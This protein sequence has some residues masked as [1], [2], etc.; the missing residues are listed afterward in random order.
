VEQLRPEVM[1]RQAEGLAD[2]LRA[3]TDRISD[4][5]AGNLLTH[6]EWPQIDTVHLTGDGD[7]YH[8]SCAAALAFEA[9][10]GVRGLPTSA[11]PFTEYTAPYLD[12]ARSSRELLIAVSA[13]GGTERVVQAIEAAKSR[14]LLTI[15]VTGK[16]GSAV[17][18]VANRTLLVEVANPEP[19]PGIRTY[20]ASL[21][22]LLLIAIRAGEAR[23]RQQP[24]EAEALRRDLVGSAD[25][26]D[27][28]A[29]A[30]KDQCRRVAR[31]VAD[32]PVMVMTG[33]G[34]NYGTALFSAAKM[35]EAAGVFAMGQDLEEWRHVERHAYPDDMPV[36]VI[37]PPSRS[38]AYAVQV[39]AQARHLGRRVI[40]VTAEPDTEMARHAH[41]V[42]P[43]RGDIR[44][45][46][47]PL[48]Y[49]L[50]SGYLASYVTEQLGRL[51]FQTDR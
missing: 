32:A 35:I 37:A 1:V 29:Q 41:V 20:Q 43:V 36:I 12:H 22:G 13:S 48:L 45:E 24:S 23:G 21:L 19:S 4:R 30:I 17:T 44:E 46:F 14:G 33:S 3:M 34:P 11:L 28:T 26:I 47:S 9:I 16:P 25:A 31:L 42:L 7:S 27:A 8:A 40:A 5:T 51:L 15:A 10:G 39:A 50:F 18:Q 2:D 38:H 6:S 49:H